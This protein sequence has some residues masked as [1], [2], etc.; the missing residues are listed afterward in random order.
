VL[1]LRAVPDDRVPECRRESLERVV[2]R[3]V[4]TSFE[5]PD[6]ARRVAE[7]MLE[8]SAPDL[9]W[10]DVLDGTSTIGWLSRRHAREESEVGDL[11][12]DDP[13]RAPE[14][15]P[16]LLAL[17]RAEGSR[18]LAILAVPGDGARERLASCPEFVTRATNMALALDGPLADPGELD[19][20]PMSQEEFDSFLDD[21]VEGYIVEL[22]SAG[23]SPG[24]ARAMGEQQMAEL[25]PAGLESPGQHFFTGWVGGTPVGTL[26]LSTERP[27]AFVYDIVVLES[28]RRRGYGEALMNAGARWC[29]D[30]GHPALGLNVFAHNP[31][32]RALYD[33]LGYHVTADFR[34]VVLDGPG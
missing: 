18:A 2:A 28:Q 30:R 34:T 33:K 4:R 16:T 9:T 23:M 1:E 29:R 31:G 7:E 14:L 22:T 5:D 26:W 27:M 20:R 8:R 32:A 19:L 21:S 24:A 15:L 25:I 3:R 13:D 12:L 11:E 6:Q 17:A 10:Y